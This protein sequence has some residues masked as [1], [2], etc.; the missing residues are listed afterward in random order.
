MR[1]AQVAP[2]IESVPPRLYGGTERV[3]S[4]LTEELVRKGHEVTLFASGDSV[5]RSHL[6][7]GAPRALRLDST[8]AD[9]LPHHLLMVEKIWQHADDFDIIHNH[10]DHLLFPMLRRTGVPSLTTLHGRLDISDLKPLFR[11]YKEMPLASISASQRRPLYWANWQGTVL[12]GLPLDLYAPSPHHDGYLAF[13]G[14]VSPEKGLEAAVEIARRSGR[15]LKI[16]A[17]VDPADRE[18]YQ[19]KIVPLL[20]DP[21]I[22]FLGE[23]KD[24]EKNQFLGAAVALLFPV[25]WPE[26]FGMVM[27][28]AM[29][30]GTPIVAFNRGSVPEVIEEGVTGFFV[31]DV[32][33]AVQAVDRIEQLDRIKIRRRFETRFTASRMAEEYLRLY[34]RQVEAFAAQR[35]DARLLAN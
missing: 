24:S 2:L 23:I 6:V 13:L 8:V 25:D 30:S 5:T 15:P 4:Y 10:I 34:R 32:Q 12:H 20:K 22:E 3:V 26:P 18:Y 14:R 17:K 28:E 7:A 11:E 1:I 29:A 35:T 21:N 31:D 9:P 27:I 16:A 19:C 33:G